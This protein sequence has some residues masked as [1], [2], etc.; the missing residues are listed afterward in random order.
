MPI[1]L[2][3]MLS[4]QNCLCLSCWKLP[5]AGSCALPSWSPPP[6]PRHEQSPPPS[7]HLPG[8]SLPPP[9]TL[10]WF[11]GWRH[12]LRVLP[13]LARVWR[14]ALGAPSALSLGEYRSTVVSHP[15][16]LLSAVASW[17]D[18]VAYFFPSSLN[19]L[20]LC[21]SA[22][23]GQHFKLKCVY[24]SVSYSCF[25]PFQHFLISWVTV[26]CLSLGTAAAL[27]GP[28]LCWGHCPVPWRMRS[29]RPHASSSPLPLSVSRP[30]HT[31]PRGQ[32]SLG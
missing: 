2:F 5:G 19:F 8:A 18:F 22:S 7:W 20:V 23:P 25:S 17:S 31:R 29:S 21:W 3:L 26:D 32:K 6:G 30:G 27:D 9:L 1:F 28:V 12:G 11:P 16:T 4:H 15:D 14:N 10:D 24:H 13:S